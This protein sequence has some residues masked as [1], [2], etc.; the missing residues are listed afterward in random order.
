MMQTLP[1]VFGVQFTDDG[2]WL[3]VAPSRFARGT[4]DRKELRP[5]GGIALARPAKASL[6]EDLLFRRYPKRFCTVR[7]GIPFQVADFAGRDRARS[8][9]LR[10]VR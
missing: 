10:S 3:S 5:G 2:R 9:Y 4:F 1:D 8:K 6:S 7:S